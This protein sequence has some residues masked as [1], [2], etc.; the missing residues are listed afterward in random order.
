MVISILIILGCF[1]GVIIL[2]LTGKNRAISAFFGALIVYLVLIYF[3]NKDFTIIVDL[4]FGTAQDNYSN[5]HSLIL[6]ISIMIIIQICS[7]AGLFQVLAISLV[8]LS[9][10]KPLL[11]MT[12]FCI[13]CLIL[14][15]VLNNVLSIIILIPLTITVSRILNVDPSPYILT[16]AVLVNLGATM[17]SISSIDF[18]LNVG[19]LSLI[20]FAFSVLLFLMLY[21]NDI[22][23]KKEDFTILK[24]FETKIPNFANC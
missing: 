1:I 4:L 17:F 19:L 6:I 14:A 18:L 3:E 9:K 20:L 10:G 22:K 2:I 7:D 21:K 15:T 5:V 8:K 16:Q 13:V 11:L 12:I 24:E 23:I